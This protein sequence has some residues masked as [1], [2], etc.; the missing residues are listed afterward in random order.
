M[1]IL[2]WNVNGIR[3][4]YKKNFLEWLKTSRAD[5]VCIQETKAWPEQLD[6]QLIQPFGYISY[7]NSAE[8][9]GYAGTAVYTKEKPEKVEKEIGFDKFDK[10]GRS[11]QLDFRN[12]SLINFYMPHGGR[13]KENLDI[14]LKVY[15]YL[16]G[17]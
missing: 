17:Y 4:V 10:Q 7:F 11:L 1:K 2:S 13:K 3:A 14:K 9:K 16:L 6:E 12:F 5:I 15:D 8:R